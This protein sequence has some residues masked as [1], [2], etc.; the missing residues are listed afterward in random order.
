MN[1]KI[2]IKQQNINRTHWSEDKHWK[3]VLKLIALKWSGE[4]KA[5]LVI[6][7]QPS[8]TP[9]GIISTTSSIIFITFL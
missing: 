8:K 6:F 7:K 3:T 4:I 9:G 1:D 2:L 5:D